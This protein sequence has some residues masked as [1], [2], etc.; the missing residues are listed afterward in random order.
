VKIED[1]GIDVHLVR[2]N[3]TLGKN[4]KS[5][6][7]LMHGIHLVM[8][9]NYSDNLREEVKKRNAG[10]SRTGNLSTKPPFRIPEQSNRKGISKSIRIIPEYGI[11]TDDSISGSF[12]KAYLR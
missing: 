3:Q 9:R 1:L 7:R 8:A 12:G 4:A 10:K 11:C 2:E 5:Q 6:D